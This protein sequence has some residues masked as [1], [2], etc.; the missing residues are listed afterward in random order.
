GGTGDGGT[1][2][3]GTGDGGT[4]DGGTGDGGT[5]DGGTGDGG[6]G[7]GGTGDGGTGDGG[8]GGISSRGGGDGGEGEGST[9]GGSSGSGRYFGTRIRSADELV[10]RVSGFRD[11]C[12]IVGPYL[13]DCLAERFEA[14]EK[15]LA[16]LPGHEPLR[17]ILK[18]TARDLRQIARENRDPS[19][20][21]G[22]ARSLNSAERSHRPI[23]AV[24]PERQATAKAQ[25]LAVL[26]EAQT[27][28][29]RSAENSPTRS[30]VPYQRIAAALN[31]SKV[32][33]R[34]A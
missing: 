7:D 17:K 14:L 6:T 16:G 8:G 4:G 30:I 21:R 25:A 11:L 23:V 15:D 1:G 5:G 33:L 20:P 3:G 9:F 24:A 34:S 29:L 2:D 13:I 32:L 18:E 28:L 22:K 10:D 19:R 27:K 12:G 31:S 26:E